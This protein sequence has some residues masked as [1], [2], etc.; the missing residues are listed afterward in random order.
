MLTRLIDYLKTEKITSLSTSLVTDAEGAD[1]SAGISSLMDTWIALQD[2][3][4]QRGEKPGDHDHE[5]PG[6]GPLQPG[7]GVQADGQGSH[8]C[9]CRWQ[10]EGGSEMKGTATERHP[11]GSQ[12]DE[13][14]AGEKR[15]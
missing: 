7:P 15:E 8:D 6:H 5:V 10:T 11:A 12:A 2:H 13:E 4:E 9:R 1:D 3:R 14:T